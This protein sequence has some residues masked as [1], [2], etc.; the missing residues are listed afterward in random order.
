LILILASL[1]SETVNSL[2]TNKIKSITIPYKGKLYTGF[3]KEN[4]HIL[5]ARIRLYQTAYLPVTNS[6]ISNLVDMSEKLAGRNHLLESELI[7]RK[8]YQKIKDTALIVTLCYIV[9]DIL[10]N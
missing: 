10:I 7:K 8:K 1:Q 5:K 9:L 2:H 3:D 4:G 6:M